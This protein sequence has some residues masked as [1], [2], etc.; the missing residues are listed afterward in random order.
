MDKDHID[1]PE[2]TFEHLAEDEVIHRLI[3]LIIGAMKDGKK[4][5]GKEK[6]KS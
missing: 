2:D 6:R 1:L 3:I 5:A 4:K